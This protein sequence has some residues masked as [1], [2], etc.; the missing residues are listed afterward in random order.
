[1]FSDGSE[2]DDAVITKRRKAASPT[3]NGAGSDE[4][5]SDAAPADGD[6]LF[7]SDSDAEMEDAPKPKTRTLD[8][9]DLDSGDDD[10]RTERRGYTRGD[11]ED[12]ERGG[13]DMVHKE[14]TLPLHQLPGADGDPVSSHHPSHLVRY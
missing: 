6:D 12:D 5:L 14:K 11:D 10:E 7:G 1:M 3:K 9:G 2:D 8:D 13:E 4:D